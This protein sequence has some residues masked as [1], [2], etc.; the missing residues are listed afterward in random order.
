VNRRMDGITRTLWALFIGPILGA[1]LWALWLFVHQPLAV[2]LPPTLLAA[3]VLT[4]LVAA[5]RG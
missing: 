3:W 5:F 1:G 4:G 2:W